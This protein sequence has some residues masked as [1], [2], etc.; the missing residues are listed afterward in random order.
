MDRSNKNDKPVRNEEKAP[1]R[2]RRSSSVPGKSSRHNAGIAG[3]RKK[4]HGKNSSFRYF[5]GTYAALWAVL[6]VVL[7]VVLW[8]NL[9]NYQRDYDAAKAAGAP[10]LAMQENMELFTAD[11][12]GDVIDTKQLDI[13]SRFET[14]EQYKDFYKGYLQNK[15]VRAVLDAV[16][17]A[18]SAGCRTFLGAGSQA[19][20]G[21]V[22]GVKLGPDTP[23]HPETGYG[24]GKLCAGQMSRIL[25]QQLGMKHIWV[26][27]LSTYGP[28]DGLHTMVMSGIIKMLN[29]ERPQYTKGEQMWD[30]LYCGD[31]ARAFYLAAERGIDGSVYCI[32]SG[33]VRPLADYIRIIRDTI[34]PSVEV[35]MGEVPYYDKQ[36]MYLC[37]DIENLKKDTGFE[38]QVSFEEGIQRTVDWYKEEMK[39]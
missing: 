15:N 32:G 36:V 19:E 24:I 39:K 5:L 14:I 23:V 33:Q 1:V 4:R 3:K 6:T 17:L 2:R 25:C 37:A 31:A 21:R 18:K 9:S 29:R 16:H 27:I 20:Y 10:E 38:P 26:R 12:I 28:H 11:K 34:D 30:Y 8:K 7:C 13:S 35:G 22:D